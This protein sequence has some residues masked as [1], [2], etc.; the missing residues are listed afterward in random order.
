VVPGP[1]RRPTFT[2]GY[3]LRDDRITI[4]GITGGGRTFGALG[5]RG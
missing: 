2:I 4:L 3:S 5:R 1:T